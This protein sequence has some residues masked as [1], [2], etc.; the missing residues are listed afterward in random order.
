MSVTNPRSVTGNVFP[1]VRARE[2][3]RSEPA[4]HT[5]IERRI[6]HGGKVVDEKQRPVMGVKIRAGS[7][8]GVTDVKGAWTL[9]GIARESTMITVTPPKTF[10]TPPSQLVEPGTTDTV[11]HLRSGTSIQGRVIPPKGRSFRHGNLLATWAASA[12]G[13]A[14]SSR[15]YFRADGKFE[16]PGIPPG[17]LV[18]VR[19]SVFPTEDGVHL[20]P[21]TVSG[22]KAGAKSIEIH[23]RTGVSAQVWWSIPKVRPSRA[24]PLCSLAKSGARVRLA[25]TVHSRWAGCLKVRVASHSSWANAKS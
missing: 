12:D 19:A 13:P 22:I 6:H 16:M 21:G 17:V 3:G 23:L 5:A 11:I 2:C 7:K 15:V 14:G 20:A 25:T 10:V 4:S 1:T 24:R 9:V 18:T 8:Q